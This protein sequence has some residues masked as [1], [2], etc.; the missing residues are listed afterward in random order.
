MPKPSRPEYTRAIH[1]RLIEYFKAGAFKRHCAQACRLTEAELDTWL[2]LGR[3]GR[4]PYATLWR[5]VEQAIADDAL[6]NQLVISRAAAGQG[7]PRADV[8][9]AQWNLER[10]HPDLYGRHA[11]EVTPS[12]PTRPAAPPDDGVHVPKFPP[13]R[14]TN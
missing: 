10:K 3:A 5:D 1:D 9:A 8:R 7:S 4:E 12:G 6:R 14:A 13:L 2:E 11:V